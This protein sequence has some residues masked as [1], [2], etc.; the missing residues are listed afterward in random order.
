LHM[1]TINYFTVGSAI[2]AESSVIN[3]RRD[4]LSDAHGS[5]TGIADSSCQLLNTYR[6][7][8]YGDLL[9]RTGIATDPL[10]TWGGRH[11]YRRS[12]NAQHYTY[13]RRRH[14]SHKPA[15]WNTSDPI[16]YSYETNMY[17]YSG[18]NP[19]TRIDPSG[20][21]FLIMDKCFEER[22]GT[23]GDDWRRLREYLDSMCEPFK[24]G[25]ND[26]GFIAL[27]TDCCLGDNQ[28][29]FQ[30]I[31]GPLPPLHY[32]DAME[33]CMSK[34]CN[35]IKP[36]EGT[37]YCNPGLGRCKD[38]N[39]GGYYSDGNGFTVCIPN[40]FRLSGEVCDRRP[41]N[42]GRWYLG[43]PIAKE[44]CQKNPQ[45]FAVLHEMAHMCYQ[46]GVDPKRDGTYDE[47]D[48]DRVACCLLS[49]FYDASKFRTIFPT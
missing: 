17:V 44:K 46:H 37:V 34:F 29:K 43:C 20:L 36:S 4:Y 16:G 31:G 25:N 39:I 21:Y 1:A 32:T 12:I 13:V 38:P 33:S 26:K 23:K 27:K 18:N 3:G 14:Y 7:N 41:G 49:G 10:F 2:L 47:I 24:K 42:H 8:P 45:L 48:A 19:V 40:L 15:V 6:F 28:S 11:G 35:G 30:S 9:K 22:P 5:V